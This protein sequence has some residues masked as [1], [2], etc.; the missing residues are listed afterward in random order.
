M[1]ADTTSL[2]SLRD[3]HKGLV[4]IFGTVSALAKTVQ[5]RI[6]AHRKARDAAKP[7]WVLLQGLQAKVER[8]QKKVAGHEAAAQRHRDEAVAARKLASAADAAAAEANAELEATRKEV[9]A[10]AAAAGGRGVAGG[11]PPNPFAF[12]IPDQARFMPEYAEIKRQADE[13]ADFALQAY[14]A[15]QATN[16]QRQPA[17]QPADPDDDAIID[18]LAVRP[19]RARP[20]P[21]DALPGVGG[22]VLAVGD[23]AAAAA[24]ARAAASGPA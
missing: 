24:A 13:F 14:D 17:G 16:T 12:V 22:A 6:D 23:A 18:D 10:A 1:P 9:A 21:Q 5:A 19:K 15:F 2:P 11:A 8:I 4:A 3:C 7:P 20:T